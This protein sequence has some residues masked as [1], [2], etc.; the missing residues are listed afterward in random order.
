MRNLA[1]II[2]AA[3]ACGCLSG[4]SK[5]HAIVNDVTTKPPFVCDYGVVAVDGKPV[6]R[7]KDSFVTVV[8]MVELEPGTHTLTVRLADKDGKKATV[9]GDFAAGKGYRIR[10]ENGTLSIVERDDDGQR[11]GDIN[12]EKSRK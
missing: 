3:T 8:P 12:H 7:C 11:P 5:R 1:I 2:L 4:S 10:S 6:T 9:T